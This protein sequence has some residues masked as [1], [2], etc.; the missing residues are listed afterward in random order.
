MSV[1]HKKI[2]KGMV[3]FLMIGIFIS[4][5]HFLD[6]NSSSIQA[7]L[8][9]YSKRTN[10]ITSNS[11]LNKVIKDLSFFPVNGNRFR[12]S[13]LETMKAIVIIM[14]EK[15]CPIS[16]RYGSLLAFLEEKYSKKGVKFIYIYTGRVKQEKSAK[17]DLN[18]F[19]FKGPYIIDRKQK[20]VN[21][22]SAQTAGDV[23]ILTPK[24]RVIYKGPV[25]D[26]YQVLKPTS[27]PS[28][29]YLIDA[30]EII[31]SGKSISPKEIPTHDCNINRSV[32]RKKVFWKDVAPIIQKKCTI[33]H[34]PS[35][36][37]PID[38]GSY[39]DV[40]GRRIMFKYVVENDLMPPWS[41]DPSTGPWKNDLSLT[42]K[43]KLILLKWLDSGCPRQSGGKNLFLIKKASQFS[44]TVPDYVISLPEVVTIPSEGLNQYKK[45]VI[46]TSFKEDKW[47]K[48]IEP[49]LKPKVIHHLVVNIMDESF[50]PTTPLR[51]GMDKHTLDRLIPGELKDI[52][53]YNA[54]VFLPR[55]SKIG[56]EIH[57]ESIGKEVI[58]D[59]TKLKVFFYQAPPKYQSTRL[60]FFN[61]KINIPP[62]QP[63]YK[64]VLSYKIKHELSI[65]R[66]GVHMHLRGK[67]GEV[68]IVN[69]SGRRKRIFGMDPYMSD[70]FYTFKHPVKVSK[71][72]IVECVNWFDNSEKNPMNPDPKKF[73][74]WGGFREDEMAMCYLR[75][76]I[77]DKNIS[78]QKHIWVE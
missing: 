56:L 54:G 23:F 31:I 62:Y 22:L 15:N 47:I 64:S 20:I 63:N 37:G 19:G 59:F 30:L 17:E 44:K 4:C 33:C 77:P 71:E 52:D 75:V 55:N 78:H 6:Q 5:T 13:E 34:N 49:V 2:I 72:S 12:L 38:Y 10:K 18:R 14:R 76:L 42:L 36:T 51:F 57:Y 50:A 67:A 3:I 61:K 8:F 46:Q 11:T 27:Q 68:F 39:E 41:L 70:R 25:D 58:D 28:T 66:V 74:T 43:E 1:L 21:A 69:P 35:G 65:W 32:I 45:F 7:I 26:Q 53:Q 73:V 48:K 9:P 24:L 40:A 16:K 60:T 29:H